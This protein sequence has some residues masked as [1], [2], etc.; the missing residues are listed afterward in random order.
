M[1]RIPTGPYFKGPGDYDMFVVSGNELERRRVQL[2]DSNYDFVEVKE[3]INPGDSIVTSDMTEYA[4][5]KNLK[6]KQ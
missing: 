6:I 5:K 4:N 3:G 1:V 2:G